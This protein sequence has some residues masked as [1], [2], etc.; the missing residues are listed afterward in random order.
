MGLITPSLQNHSLF[1]KIELHLPNLHEALQSQHWNHESSSHQ[2]QLRTYGKKSSG[3]AAGHRIPDGWQGLRN[4]D[5]QVS[6]AGQTGKV[7]YRHFTSLFLQIYVFGALRACPLN[8]A[9][10]RVFSFLFCFYVEVRDCL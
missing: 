3:N 6:K 4:K 5:G 1:V 8:H 9:R 10:V 7:S 2:R